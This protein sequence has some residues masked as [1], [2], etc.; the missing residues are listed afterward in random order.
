MSGSTPVAVGRLAR[1]TADVSLSGSRMVRLQLLDLEVAGQRTC[2]T[3]ARHA[4]TVGL[5]DHRV[6]PARS[7]AAR[8]AVGEARFEAEEH[9]GQREGSAA[10]AAG[11]TEHHRLAA[12]QELAAPAGRPARTGSSGRRGLRQQRRS[13]CIQCIVVGACEADPWLPMARDRAEARR[14][15]AGRSHEPISSFGYS[16][17]GSISPAAFSARHREASSHRVTPL[18]VLVA[19]ARLRVAAAERPLVYEWHLLECRGADGRVLPTSGRR[20]RAAFLHR[21]TLKPPRS[22]SR[23]ARRAR[24]HAPRRS[25]R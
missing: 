16:T 12:A 11:C 24:T 18:P 23:R 7:R 8:G 13:V 3:P 10:A 19:G 17:L 2:A 22:G 15:R 4:G 14:S 9:L 6:Q 20:T 21:P 1:A 5:E 25:R